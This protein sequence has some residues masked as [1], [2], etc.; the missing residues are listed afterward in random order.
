[1][2]RTAKPRKARRLSPQPDGELHLAVFSAVP[3]AR[4]RRRFLLKCARRAARHL[5]RRVAFIHFI[6]IADRE[7]ARLHRAFLGQG[8]A[9]DVMSFDL[10]E[11][12][13]SPMEGEI[14]ISVN[15]ARRQARLY[16]V[17][18]YLEAARLAVHGVL[19]LAGLNDTTAAGKARM[20]AL[21]DRIL[22]EASVRP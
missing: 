2:G 5:K 10:S 20:H 8:G 19:H 6:L 21:E 7:M 1:V 22:R 18:L 14:Y 9:T 4:V 3:Q 16:G 12:S 11:S 17:P 13:Y 15:Q